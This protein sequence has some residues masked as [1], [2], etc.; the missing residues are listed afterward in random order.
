MRIPL[1]G[2]VFVKHLTFIELKRSRPLIKRGL[3]PN[4]I[5]FWN[6]TS[7]DFLYDSL[8]GTEQAYLQVNGNGT[9]VPYSSCIRA[10]TLERVVIPIL[11]K[12]GIIGFVKHTQRP[13]LYLLCSWSHRLKW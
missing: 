8:E 13:H 4:G 11:T 7:A 12:P 10:L 9:P 6:Y 1:S 3:F 5:R 2:R